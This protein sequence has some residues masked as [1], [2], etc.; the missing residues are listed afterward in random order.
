MTA[1]HAF[2]MPT[3][4]G[5]M[6]DAVDAAAAGEVVYLTRGGRRVAALES[7]ERRYAKLSRIAEFWREREQEMAESC[8]AIWVDMAND[9]SR[10]LTRALFDRVLGQLE[11]AA[12]NAAADAALADPAASIP[13]AELLAEHADVLAAHPDGE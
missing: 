2:E 12:D 5:P 6:A 13:V 4:D 9:T 8:R 10:R 1:A 3:D 7:A 11:D